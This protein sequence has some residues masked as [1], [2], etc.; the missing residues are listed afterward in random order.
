[1]DINQWLLSQEITQDEFALKIGKSKSFVSQLRRGLSNPS[2]ATL[3]RI[4]EVTGGAVTPN[5]FLT[6]PEGAT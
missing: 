4:Y 6:K 3:D 1:M 2:L 5:D